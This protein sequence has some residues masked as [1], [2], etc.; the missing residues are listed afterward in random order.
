MKSKLEQKN[1]IRLYAPV[2]N[3]EYEKTIL[4]SS[5]FCITSYNFIK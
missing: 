1:K 3:Y 2:V 5:S 4:E